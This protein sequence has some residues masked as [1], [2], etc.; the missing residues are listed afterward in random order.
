MKTEKLYEFLILSKTLNYSKAAKN[1]YITQSVLSKHIQEMEQEL[2]TKLFYRTTHGV[3]LTEPGIILAQKAEALID[4]CNSAANLI[5]LE[6]LQTK[7][8]V[9]VL[10]ATEL[11]YSSHIQFFISH[12]MERY[13]DISVNFQVQTE[14]TPEELLHNAHYDFI[15][16]PCEYLNLTTNIR[17]HLLHQHGTYV[18]LPVG[19]RLISRS[20]VY[21]RELEGE[22]LIVPFASEF[23]GPY[24]K[25]WMLTQ[26]YTHDRVNCI[27]APNLLTALFLVSIGKGIAIIPRYAKNLITNNIFLS[28]IANDLCCFN[29]YMYYN[30]KPENGAAELFYEEFRSTYPAL[31]SSES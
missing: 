15:F 9:N 10:C 21:L 19:H 12:F 7:G 25:N 30:K 11:A 8:T 18:A 4:R 6:N 26:K 31:V 13:Q 22:T 28:R 23:F 14:G 5:Q 17:Q 1:L 24:A 29:E 20:Q 2:N 16:T 3:S 27:K